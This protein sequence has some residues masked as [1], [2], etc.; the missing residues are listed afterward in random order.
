MG[1][2]VNKRIRIAKGISLNVGKKG[3]SV[4]TR[5]GN[6][7]VNSRGRVTTRIAPG[8]S[9]S[10]NLKNSNKNEKRA[11]HTTQTGELHKTKSKTT[12]IILC[13]LGF[14]GIAGLHKFYEGKFLLGVVYL[15]T[16]GLFFIGTIVDLI[17]LINKENTYIA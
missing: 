5:I 14:V 1:F 6:N 2:R 4:S 9:Y 16:F 12:S 11:T 17:N 7:T 10:T 15:L 3:V 13:C 8:I